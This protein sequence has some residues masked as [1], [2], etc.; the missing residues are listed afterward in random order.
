MLWPMRYERD[1]QRWSAGLESTGYFKALVLLEGAEAA[2]VQADDEI[3][4]V[5]SEPPHPPRSFVEAW[6]EKTA[7][8]RKPSF[9]VW[10]PIAI[11]IATAGVVGAIVASWPS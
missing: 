4:G 8:H 3:L 7:H 6:V 9:A 1:E 5:V 2:A 10:R 11:L